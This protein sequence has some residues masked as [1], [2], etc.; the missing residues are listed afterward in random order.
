MLMA[1]F[2]LKHGEAYANLVNAPSIQLPSMMRVAPGDPSHSYLWHKINGT[3]AQVGGSGM[4]M[5][6]TIPLNA[7]EK[8]IF[9]RWIMAGA[10]P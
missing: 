5:P 7:D 10:P 2:S 8:T 4:I 3:Q 6:S 9:E 1:P